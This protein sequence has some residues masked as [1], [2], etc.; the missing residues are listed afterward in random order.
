MKN[1][2]VKMLPIILL[3][4]LFTGCTQKVPLQKDKVD[5]NTSEITSQKK[6]GKKTGVWSPDSKWVAVTTVARDF[7]DTVIL[8]T[9]ENKEYETGLFKYIPTHADEY[10]F[11]IGMNQS[12]DPYIDFVEWCPDSKKVL[13]SYSFTDDFSTRQTGVAVFSLEKMSVDWMMKLASSEGGNSDISKP[14]NFNWIGA[15]YGIESGLVA[16]D[17]VNGEESH[18]R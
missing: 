15:G 18:N 1:T 11:K 2:C 9:I 7:I 10:G 13:L 17:T 8:D 3:I 16:K 5:Q 6:N 14:E 4:L 12:P